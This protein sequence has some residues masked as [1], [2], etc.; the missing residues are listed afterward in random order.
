MRIDCRMEVGLGKQA[1]EDRILVDNTI[2][3]GGIF[4]MQIPNGTPFVVAVAD[5]VGGNKAGN[6][7]SHIATEG[8]LSMKLHAISN[9][10]AL[11]AR[12]K[13]INALIID[14]SLQEKQFEKMATTLSGLYFTGERWFLFHIG[15]SRVYL[16]D[17]PYL[18]QITTDHTWVSEMLQAGLTEDEIKSSGKSSTIT[19]CLGNG[20]ALV[21]SKL[22]VFDVTSSIETSTSIFLTSDGIHDFIPHPMLERGVTSGTPPEGLLRLCMELARSRGS[23]DDLSMICISLREKNENHSN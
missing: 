15:N 16:L 10:V 9:E 1:I 18:K 2:L 6:W 4:S 7:A 5:G 22:Q 8:L 11:E 14:R 20:D 12:I 19:S 3:A 23:T 13:Q 17:T 21:A